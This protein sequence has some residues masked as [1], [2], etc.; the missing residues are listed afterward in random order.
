M[1]RKI[2]VL[3]SVI[4]AYGCAATDPQEEQVINE[5]P[6]GDTTLDPAAA[7]EPVIE[8]EGIEPTFA[9]VDVD[10]DGRISEEEAENYEAVADFFPFVD[11]DNDGYLSEVEFRDLKE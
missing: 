8:D 9:E 11:E 10:G 5:P 3:L 4:F 7:N 6:R 2:V 1:N